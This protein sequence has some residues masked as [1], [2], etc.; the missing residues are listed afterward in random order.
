MDQK[1]DSI[2]ENTPG[3]AEDGKPAKPEE[4]HGDVSA[5]DTG[6]APT[7]R[8][9]GRPR[10]VK[11]PAHDQ[12]EGAANVDV[13][14][15]AARGDAESDSLVDS[16]E[17]PGAS[18][19]NESDDVI[20]WSL[21]N[22]H[23]NTNVAHLEAPDNAGSAHESLFDNVE[24]VE[25]D[26]TPGE[27]FTED[28]DQ[29]KENLAAA[30]VQPAPIPSPFGGDRNVSK[31]KSSPDG[32]PPQSFTSILVRWA[33]ILAISGGAIYALGRISKPLLVSFA[34]WILRAQPQDDDDFY[35]R[36]VS[37]EAERVTSSTMPKHIDTIGE[38]KANASVVLHSEIS[39]CIKE[40]LFVEG[41]SV[42]KGEVLIRL[43]DDIH[44]AECRANQSHYV[45]AKTEF[46]RQEKM[47]ASGAGSKRDFDKAQAEMN[48]AK[49]KMESSEAQLKRTE[50][51]APFDGIIGIIDICVGAYVQSN[52][53]LVTVVDQTP[54]KVKFGVPGK[55]VNNVGVG[56]SVELRVDAH[57][58]RVFRGTVEAVDSYVD[59]STNCVALRASVPN[60]DG[61]LKA[62]LF[63]SVSLIIGLQ[64]ETITIDESAV[65]RV[66]EQEYV[67]C[68]NKGQARRLP[69][70]TGARERGRIEVIAGLKDKQIVIT[71]GQRG[72]SD[73]RYV[74][75][76]NMELEAEQQQDE[77][78]ER[79]EQASVTK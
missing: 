20:G 75:I 6:S 29:A 55:F 70:L 30:D 68:V 73:G 10:K 54:M 53:E 43:D 52:Q 45:A 72:L 8:K 5:P 11:V 13:D 36:E 47:L 24:D 25:T 46:E 42:K 9:R 59:S 51:R 19:R 37:V 58:D 40:I 27:V 17:L 48:A 38:L 69:I 4:H 21:H 2:G 74:R 15:M 79:A 22:E 7:T 50:I 78:A 28:R 3:N 32:K 63:A 57:K 34:T 33:L 76:V 18:E 77:S 39:G 35:T 65:E 64:G 67:W 60:E 12:L 66:G 14:W 31:R 23:E 49:A 44:Q 61:A 71:S 26:R 41:S 1:D 16:V 56:Q 62:G